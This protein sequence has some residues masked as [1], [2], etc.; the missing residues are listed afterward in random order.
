M[1]ACVQAYPLDLVRTR[2]SAQRGNGTLHPTPFTPSPMAYNL[3][4][5]QGGGS[6]GGGSTSSTSSTS[7]S[8][9]TS[10][11]GRALGTSSSA[12]RSAVCSDNGGCSS[13][14]TRG[15]AAREL[16]CCSSRGSSGAGHE[17]SNGGAMVG[18]KGGRAQPSHWADEHGRVLQRQSCSPQHGTSHG[19]C[20][21]PRIQPVKAPARC[22]ASQPPFCTLYPPAGPAPHSQPMPGGGSGGGMGRPSAPAQLPQSPLL[23]RP[24]H[25][26]SR[27]H[28]RAS[29]PYPLHHSPPGPIQ[30]PQ[31]TLQPHASPPRRMHAPSNLLATPSAT[32]SPPSPAHHH[33]G[34]NSRPLFALIHPATPFRPPLLS[35]PKVPWV[36]NSPCPQPIPPLQHPQPNPTHTCPPPHSSPP[37]PPRPAQHRPAA[38]AA[39]PYTA[40]RVNV[41]AT[42]PPR[43][44][45]ACGSSVRA[46]A[47]LPPSLAR[48]CMR[49]P[50]VPQPCAASAWGL[51]GAAACPGKPSPSSALLRPPRLT[52]HTGLTHRCT[53]AAAATATLRRPIA[54]AAAAPFTAAFCTT[55]LHPPSPAAPHYRG[56]VHA[57]SHIVQ[58]EGVLGLYR[59]LGAT[60]L[61]VCVCVHV[62]VRE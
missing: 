11:S 48:S 58:H 24:T 60:L 4:V 45:L 20:Q 9:S 50:T 14:S 17:A 27:S 61:Q 59:G 21:P 30:A 34:L 37:L 46:P 51:T 3:P 56:I 18:K 36:P 57:L 49:P 39:A 35:P 13:S 55:S 1:H 28:P 31:P 53:A 22:T 32:P 62:C 23:L 25:L 41:P 16:A 44:S 5:R 26:A 15:G 6:G 8:T 42:P 52:W 2:L 29:A 33:S 54:A 10:S 7:T 40:P 38:M 47:A 12:T 43:P 19:T